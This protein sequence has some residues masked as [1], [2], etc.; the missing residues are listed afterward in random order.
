[1][2]AKESPYIQL[3]LFDTI[4]DDTPLFAGPQS[5]VLQRAK[6]VRWLQYEFPQ[7]NKR[8]ERSLS[9][10]E[11]L[12][13]AIKQI[14][15]CLKSDPKEGLR[16]ADILRQFYLEGKKDNE[17]GRTLALSSERIRQ[18]RTQSAQRLMNGLG[19]GP[20]HLNPRVVS[21]LKKL[22][23]DMIGQDPCRYLQVR[24]KQLPLRLLDFIG[25][26]AFEMHDM[27]NQS[28]IAYNERAGVL[29][30]HIYQLVRLLR[31]SYT[32]MPYEEVMRLL[33]ARVKA[34]KQE[35]HPEWIP[36]IISGHHWIESS[37]GHVQLTYEG[38]HY[39]SLKIARI[40]YE[41]KRIHKDEILRIYNRQNSGGTVSPAVN[42]LL[43]KKDP[44]F[45]CQG[46]SGIWTFSERTVPQMPVMQYVREYVAAHP[47]PIR[48]KAVWKQLRQE[49]YDYPLHTIRSYLLRKCVSAVG[50]SDLV[51]RT[52][53]LSQHPETRWRYK[54]SPSRK[55]NK[56][57][58]YYGLIIDKVKGLLEQA[59]QHRLPHRQIV[60]ICKPLIPEHLETNNV[61]KI[62]SHKLPDNIVREKVEGVACLRL[63]PT[64]E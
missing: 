47:E 15:S 42:V 58:A 5:I 39:P 46:K 22:V 25:L 13:V 6:Q 19:L 45:Q 20:I 29:R 33:P 35:F 52:D 23:P 50:D 24:K 10:L 9:A 31:S 44:R 61:Y 3:S 62:I 14:I 30:V 16:Y 54:L 55:T 21:S 11:R 53:C 63:V 56:T 60:A 18:I 17:I 43:K 1:M 34:A 4:P 64:D 48:V 37:N 7:I 57:P 38:L 36:C 41:H 26:C 12:H 59:D 8:K 32:P 27:A 2:T 28:F 40:I 51:C 49:G